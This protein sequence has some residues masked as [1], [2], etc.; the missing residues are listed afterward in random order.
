MIFAHFVG[1]VFLRNK[2]IDKHK[3]DSMVVQMFHSFIVTTCIAIPLEI[4]SRLSIE[5]YL[6]LLLSHFI[7]DEM[8][9]KIDPNRNWEK[10]GK[11]DVSKYKVID[12]IVHIM[13]ILIIWGV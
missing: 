5:N 9:G 6:I 2:I 7:V 8:K 11:P 3:H 12:Q 1:D 10:D 13:F 4:Y